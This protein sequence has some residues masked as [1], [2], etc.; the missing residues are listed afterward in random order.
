M[1]RPSGAG[2]AWTETEDAQL[3]DEY[4]LGIT[5]S[6]IAKIHDRT[7]GGILARLKRHGLID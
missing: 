4:N 1:N 6:E 7:R 3:D 5:I 2:A